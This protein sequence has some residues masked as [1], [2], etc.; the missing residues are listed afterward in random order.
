MVHAR[1]ER[2]L[3]RDVGA[4]LKREREVV[5][6]KVRRRVLDEIELTP[7]RRWRRLGTAVGDTLGRAVRSGGRFEA[8][9]GLGFGLSQGEILELQRIA[10]EFLAQQ[11]NAFWQGMQ[12]RVRDRLAREIIEGLTRGE[13]V[14]QL[15]ERIAEIMGRTVKDSRTAARTESTTAVNLGQDIIRRE[16]GVAK[17]Q[18]ITQRDERVRPAHAAMEGRIVRMNAVFIV[19]GEQAR[20]PGDP[21]LSP[22]NRINCRCL[23][24]GA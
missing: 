11:T 8:V 15:A 19:G 22:G 18:W 17:K 2:E 23:S 21:N 4:F 6:G 12:R 14:E 16:F 24:I 9:N 10:A 5:V 13:S 1:R 3:R 20:W 7:T